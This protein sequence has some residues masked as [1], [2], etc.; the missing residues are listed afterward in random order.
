MDMLIRQAV[1]VKVR[2][3][4]DLVKS[5]LADIRENDTRN[6]QILLLS[7]RKGDRASYSKIAPFQ[8]VFGQIQPHRSLWKEFF[9][10]VEFLL[11]DEEIA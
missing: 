10:Y 5:Y 9:L 7:G 11:M 1:S 2:K 3:I 8:M 6:P 4:E